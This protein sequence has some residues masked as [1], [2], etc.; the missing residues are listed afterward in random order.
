VT[1]GFF[2]GE[3]TAQE[4]AKIPVA[5]AADFFSQSLLESDDST[6][7]NSFIVKKGWWLVIG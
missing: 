7:V 6:D 3:A 1:A 4:L 5:N 2:S